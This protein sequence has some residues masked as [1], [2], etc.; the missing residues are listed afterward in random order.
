MELT[1]RFHLFGVCL[2][3]LDIGDEYENKQDQEN[4]QETEQSER[5]E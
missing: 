1:F 5:R 2:E 4:D 3:D